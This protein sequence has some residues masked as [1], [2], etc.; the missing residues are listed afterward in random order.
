MSYDPDSHRESYEL[1]QHIIVFLGFKAASPIAYTPCL[2]ETRLCS[3]PTALQTFQI[4]YFN[5]LKLLSY[6]A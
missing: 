6:A 5:S 2:P 4:I 1:K 3:Q